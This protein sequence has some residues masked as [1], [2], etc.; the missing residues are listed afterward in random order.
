MRRRNETLRRACTHAHPAMSPAVHASTLVM[1]LLTARERWPD[2]VGG[3]REI[4]GAVEMGRDV[5]ASRARPNQ[6]I[7]GRRRH[8]ASEA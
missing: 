4:D 8:L 3:N 6:D 5:D 2:E 1:I 7:W